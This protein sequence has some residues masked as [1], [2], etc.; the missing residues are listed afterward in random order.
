MLA[1]FKAFLYDTL[2]NVIASLLLDLLH[3]VIHLVGSVPGCL[4]VFAPPLCGLA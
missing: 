3:L 4:A 1:H 2:I